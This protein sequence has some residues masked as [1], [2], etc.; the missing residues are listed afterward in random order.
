MSDSYVKECIY[1]KQKIRMSDES[2]KWL[3]YNKDNSMHN[4]RSNN[5]ESNRSYSYTVDKIVE[6]LESIG[7]YV[8]IDKLMSSK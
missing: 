4:C 7:V 8:D 1:C 3:P 6:K 5:G 2:G